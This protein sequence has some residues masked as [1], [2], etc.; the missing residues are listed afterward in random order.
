MAR[1]SSLA[2]MINLEF[3]NGR[4]ACGFNIFPQLRSKRDEVRYAMDVTRLQEGSPDTRCHNRM[5][6]EDA[7]LGKA[8]S[9]KRPRA[10]GFYLQETSVRSIE[11]QSGLVISSSRRDGEMGVTANGKGVLF[12]W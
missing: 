10:G 8:A 3:I 11:T 4:T 5:N 12:G 2:H 9:H 6:P 1:V 7:T